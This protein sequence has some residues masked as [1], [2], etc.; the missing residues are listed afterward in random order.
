MVA[1]RVFSLEEIRSCCKESSVLYVIMK[2]AEEGNLK[3]LDRLVLVGC[4]RN[5]SN[6]ALL[7]DILKQQHNFKEDITRQYLDKLKNRYYPI[8]M[9]YFLPVFVHTDHTNISL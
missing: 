3:Y 4:F 7:L 1:N 8:T 5:F 6:G 2:R 9:R